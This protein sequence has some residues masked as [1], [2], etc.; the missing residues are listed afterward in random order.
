MARKR[1]CNGPLVLALFLL[2]CLSLAYLLGGPLLGEFLDSGD[3]LESGRRLTSRVRHL[4]TLQEIRTRIFEFLLMAWVFAVGGCIGCF[5][6]VV[7][8]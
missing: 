7:V 3:T 8:Y 4:H 1:R 6:N 5:L 2:A